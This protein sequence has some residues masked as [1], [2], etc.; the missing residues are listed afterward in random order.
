MD[1]RFLDN[2]TTQLRKGILELCI[3]NAMKSA[4]LYGYD[5]VKRLRGID[6]LMIGEGTIY[7]ILSRFKREGLVETSIEESTEGP[8]RKYYKLT[9]RGEEHLAR[10]NAHWESISNGMDGLRAEGPS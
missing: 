5:I 1:T 9:K 8:A 7:P 4:R 6:G 3:L 2:W 10:M